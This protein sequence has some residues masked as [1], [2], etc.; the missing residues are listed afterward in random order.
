M[1]LSIQKKFRWEISEILSYPCYPV[2]PRVNF[3]IE[4][5]SACMPNGTVHSNSGC[6]DLGP[7]PPHVWLLFL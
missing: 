7:K 3:K 6:I 1:A 5:L 4:I 2:L